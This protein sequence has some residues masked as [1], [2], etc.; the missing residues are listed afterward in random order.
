[1]RRHLEEPDAVLDFPILADLRASGITDYLAVPLEL[2]TG[3][4]IAITLA[5]DKV[6]GFRDEE[7]SRN[8]SARPL[9]GTAA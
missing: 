2:S 8:L 1:V 3:R 7:L 9:S 6:G 5:T 4:W